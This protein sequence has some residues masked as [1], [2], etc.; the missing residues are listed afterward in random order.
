MDR[1][2]AEDLLSL[3]YK[4]DDAGFE[5]GM[6][7]YG[8]FLKDDEETTGPAYKNYKDARAV[9]EDVF[10]QALRKAVKEGLLD[11]ADIPDY[12][13]QTLGLLNV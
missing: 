10:G 7:H 13:V 1:K 5:H 2:F 6:E 8:E 4:V 3:S 11:V 9:L 12:Y